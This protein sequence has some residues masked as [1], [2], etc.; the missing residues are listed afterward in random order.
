MI[1]NYLYQIQVKIIIIT[2][3]LNIKK[4]STIIIAIII[5]INII[6]IIIIII[7]TDKATQINILTITIIH[8]NIIS[9]IVPIKI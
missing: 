7:I 4:I 1:D 9:Q 5:N 3:I 8:L 6:I 2:K